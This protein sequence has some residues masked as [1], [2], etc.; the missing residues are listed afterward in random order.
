[1]HD[2]NIARAL[3][4]AIR[5]SATW[6]DQA[7]SCERTAAQLR[8]AIVDRAR[9]GRW[10]RDSPIAIKYTVTASGPW[11]DAQPRE[12]LERYFAQA[13]DWICA[14]HG[15]ENVIAWMKKPGVSGIAA[16]ALRVFVTP[17]VSKPRGDT[18]SSSNFVGTR[19]LYSVGNL[20]FWLAVGKGFGLE[21]PASFEW[22]WDSVTAIETADLAWLKP[23]IDVIERARLA[24]ATRRVRS[25]EIPP[26]FESSII[27]RISDPRALVDFAREHGYAIPSGRHDAVAL[28]AEDDMSPIVGS[29]RRRSEGEQ[30]ER[31]GL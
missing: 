17:I 27:A 15:R 12:E 3:R 7:R 10:R 4:E 11:C 16:P 23:A 26:G 18:L 8:D 28:V 14:R 1:M 20:D 25:R 13:L 5:D 2:N 22:L 6:G 29:A 24:P 21:P 9:S 30:L 31:A 19:K